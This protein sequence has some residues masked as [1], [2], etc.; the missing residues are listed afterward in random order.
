MDRL[1]EWA[2]NFQAK[3]SSS[4]S[5]KICQQCQEVTKRLWLSFSE[6]LRGSYVKRRRCF[7]Q[8]QKLQ[9][10][11]NV[12]RIRDGRPPRIWRKKLTS[13]PKNAGSALGIQFNNTVTEEESMGFNQAPDQHETMINIRA[14][15]NNMSNILGHQTPTSPIAVQETAAK[16]PSDYLVHELVQRIEYLQGRMRFE[17]DKIQ[18]SRDEIKF[19]IENL[20]TLD[21][22]VEKLN[23]GIAAARV[24]SIPGM[25]QQLAETGQRNPNLKRS[26]NAHIKTVKSIDQQNRR[27]KDYPN[28]LMELERQ[29]Q[30][31]RR[32]ETASMLM[33]KWGTPIAN[34]FS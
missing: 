14:A 7:R 5:I 4:W 3:A 32:R 18:K 30:A 11:L 31:A 27:M 17:E 20:K 33:D 15:M 16:L 34:C 10:E 29:I 6:T 23:S 26:R 28:K 1:P 25:E 24:T 2:R 12:Q 19:Y 8:R 22:K 21:D 13:S 9:A